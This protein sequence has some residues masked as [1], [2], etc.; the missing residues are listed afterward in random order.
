[1][2]FY[3]RVKIEGLKDHIRPN[4]SGLYKQGEIYGRNRCNAEGR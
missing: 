2:C 4:L 3:F 1:M